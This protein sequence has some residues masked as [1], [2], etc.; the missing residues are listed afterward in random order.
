MIACPAGRVH[1][2]RRGR[3]GGGRDLT[4]RRR[5]TARRAERADNEPTSGCWTRAWRGS[6]S[7]AA[8]T[9]Q[10]RNEKRA[11]DTRWQHYK[12][13]MVRQWG[14]LDV[15]GISGARSCCTGVDGE[16]RALLGAANGGL[17]AGFGSTEEACWSSGRQER[18]V[19]ELRA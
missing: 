11:D 2:R 18:A 19:G 4:L 15:G 17:G 16:A 8:R 3:R 1:D 10:T 14:G 9:R 12:D 6:S 13:T 5:R 7:T